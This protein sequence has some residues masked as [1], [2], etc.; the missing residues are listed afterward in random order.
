M[1]NLHKSKIKDQNKK[2]AEIRAWHWSSARAKLHK[3]RSL[4]LIRGA[5]EVN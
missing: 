3:S 5:I 1:I 2:G 4:G